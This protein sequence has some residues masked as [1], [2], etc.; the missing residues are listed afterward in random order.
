MVRGQELLEDPPAAEILEDI[1][2]N[3]IVDLLP[4]SPDS[5]KAKKRGGLS[6]KSAEGHPFSLGLLCL[7]E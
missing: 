6:I 1:P 4:F 2:E 7:E 3:T 5:C